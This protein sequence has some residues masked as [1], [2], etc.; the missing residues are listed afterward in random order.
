MTDLVERARA[1]LRHDL[2]MP[3]E[4]QAVI[5]DLADA[6]DRAQAEIDRLRLI[7]VLA[8]DEAQRLRS[9]R[10]SARAAIADLRAL[11]EAAGAECARLETP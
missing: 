2:A 9:E 11:L 7:L 6:L 4:T 1:L 8:H 3:E 5:Y 10:D